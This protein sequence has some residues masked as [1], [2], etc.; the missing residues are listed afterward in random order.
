M[1]AFRTKAFSLLRPD[2][3]EAAQGFSASIVGV[4]D[5]GESSCSSPDDDATDG[6]D[7]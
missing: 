6:V 7:S 2:S 4:G 5:G 1:F 3:T